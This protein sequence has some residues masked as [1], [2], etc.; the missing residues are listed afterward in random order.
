M[1]KLAMVGLGYWGSHLLRNF[2]ATPGVRVVS[3][4]DIHPEA[5][6]RAL[7][8]APEAAGFGD[9]GQ[10][11]E[12][13][14]VDAVIIA[15][16]AKTHYPLARRAL[17]SGHHV[18]LEKPATRTV[19]E[20]KDLADLA[21]S[22]DLLLHIDHTPVFP[23]SVGQ[24]KAAIDD[25]KARTGLGLRTYSSVRMGPYAM[26]DDVNVI[27]DMGIHDLAVVDH[28]LDGRLPDTVSVLGRPWL[29]DWPVAEG[30]INLSY[31]ETMA[32][33]HVGWMSAEKRQLIRANF[34][35]C[36]AMYEEFQPAD[37]LRVYRMLADLERR[38][39]DQY[40]YTLERLPPYE[41][42]PGETLTRV[43][44]HFR[45]CITGN[46][47]PMSGADMGLRLAAVL[48]AAD[49]SLAKGGALVEVNRP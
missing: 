44:A 26:R 48:Q 10:L 42:P 17:A 14:A 3:L 43:C 11:L 22:A 13:P 4:C 35:D 25:A 20:M 34:G 5:L 29:A 24:L 37:K 18:L 31:G 47:K 15:T 6:A 21:S 46:A 40:R 1:L 38:L 30:V 9:F 32:T 36:L 7:E 8:K 45:D 39:P 12:G 33:I 27:A 16:P 23:P 19:A 41:T 49:V 2:L 28:L